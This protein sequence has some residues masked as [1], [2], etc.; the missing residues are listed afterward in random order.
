MEKKRYETPRII[1][2][3]R[4]ASGW[5][6][7]S[8]G[9]GGGTAGQ[10]CSTGDGDKYACASGPTGDS[11]LNCN[12]GM[13]YQYQSCGGGT[14]PDGCVTGQ[15]GTTTGYCQTGSSDASCPSTGN[16]VGNK[17]DCGAGTSY[18]GWCSSGSGPAS[19]CTT[20]TSACI[21]G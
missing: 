12:S 4:E 16:G 18:A 13:A 3:N 2:L 14:T 17:E 5:P 21:I 1:F 6:D 19:W 8:T 10:P 7:C 20:G 9:S 15:D 11:Q